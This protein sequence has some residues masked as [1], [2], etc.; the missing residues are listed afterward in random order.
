MMQKETLDDSALDLLNRIL[1]ENIGEW[2]DV[3]GR[4]GGFLSQ[5]TNYASFV[6]V[7]SIKL[8]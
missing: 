3:V 6:I 1:N 7:P 8:S 4:V 5:I 2:S